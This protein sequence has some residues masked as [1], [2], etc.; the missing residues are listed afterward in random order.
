[1]NKLTKLGLSAVAGS[2][3]AS[4]AYAGA[5]DVSGSAKMTYFS[6]DADE[7]TGNSFKMAKGITFSGSGDVNG[8]TMNYSYTMTNAAFS[9]QVVSLDMGDAGTFGISNS[10]GVAGLIAVQSVI[11]NSGEQVWDD[12]NQNDNGITSFN[13][14][15]ETNS[16]F[17]K[18]SFAGF[19]V[20]LAYTDE[21]QN[22]AS[23]EHGYVTFDMM[24][25]LQ[26]GLGGG[27]EG[28]NM[29]M[30]TFFVKYTMGNVTA[31]YQRT[32]LDF[33][34]AGTAD[35]ESDSIGIG[36]A[37]NDDLS[38]SVGM[39]EVDMGAGNND[40]ESTGVS[41]SYTMGGMSITAI[42]NSQD[43]TNGSA[44]ADDAYKELTIA[45]AF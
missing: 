14:L 1:M 28:A 15:S 20:N 29:D 45:F 30:E 40:E 44:T 41:A 4:S 43:N 39:T 33:T 31:A 38:V 23:D 42:S 2:L 37:V 6:H 17:Y 24:D 5:L 36:F 18:N 13:N 35:E 10:G 9:S 34:A 22:G 11:P 12:M 8:M 19:S 27:E 25:G 21:G 32:N 16:V 7:T 3:A 26:I